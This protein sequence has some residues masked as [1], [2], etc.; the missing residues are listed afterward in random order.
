MTDLLIRLRWTRVKRMS[1]YLHHKIKWQFGRSP[2][3][4]RDLEVWG[5]KL[6]RRGSGGRADTGGKAIRAGVSGAWG[7]PV[8]SLHVLTWLSPESEVFVLCGGS[9]PGR[10][11]LCWGESGSDE[12]DGL[13]CRA[14]GGGG[15]PQQ[16]K[17]PGG[18]TGTWWLTP[19]EMWRKRPSSL[20]F[21]KTP[22]LGWL[23]AVGARRAAWLHRVLRMEL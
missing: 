17:Q 6:E 16:S 19:E 9:A 21:Q 1:V 20:T 3:A 7:C 13:C 11:C 14:G 8:E 10:W 5:T 2:S 22:G 15:R 4:L 23:G 12:Q 18:R